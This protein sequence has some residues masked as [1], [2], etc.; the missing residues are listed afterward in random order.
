MKKT[1][2][3][4]TVA[5]AT[6]TAGIASAGT[7]ADVQARGKL[8]CGVTG[9]QAGFSAPDASGVWQGMDV[10]YCRAIAA[11]VLKDPNAVNFVPTTG[12]TRSTA[13]ASGEIDILS[14]T[15]T[16]TFSR[17][18]DLKFT[19]AG[20]NFY[21]G[22]AFMVPKALGAKSAKDL[23]GATICIQ[24]GT[25]TEL[26]LAEYFRKNN[27]TYEPVPVENN[28]DIVQKYLAGEH[29]GELI[30]SGYFPHK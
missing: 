9:G 11:A 6:L 12:Q 7:M 15:T 14:R 3:L 18:V 5:A 28:A 8:N 2:L 23:N 26:N 29:V 10:A 20:V 25:T 13:L 22:Q 21:D 1:L 17:D 16:W 24:T 19:F 4:A 27:M 30:S